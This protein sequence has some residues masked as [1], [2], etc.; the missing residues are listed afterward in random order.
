MKKTID[1]LRHF[2]WRDALAS[3]VPVVLVLALGLWAAVHF[4][5][6]APDEDLL[7][8]T[9]SE[10]PAFQAFAQQYASQLAEDGVRL[11]IEA[12]GASLDSLK[13]L[14]DPED[15]LRVAFVP[16]GLSETEES[17][18]RDSEVELVSLG[19]VSYEPI[20]VFHRDAGQPTRL[21]QLRGKRIAI[22]ERRST[23]ALLALRLLQASGVDDQ[24]SELL[25]LA[26]ED[27]RRQLQAGA[28]DAA[29]FI[30]P[31]E[32]A[33]LRALMNEPGLHAMNLAQAEAYTRQF[34]YLHRL[35]L[36]QGALDLER[37]IPAQDLNLLATTTVVVVTRN[38]HPALVSL[39]MKAMR[40]THAKPGLLHEPRFFPSPRDTDFPL[41]KD[42]E[43]FYRSGPPFLQR[44]L[45][46]WLATLIERAA[47]ALIPLLAILLPVLRFAPTLYGWRIRRRI[48]HWY[49]E[50]KYLEIQAQSA[51]PECSRDALRA[52]LD[53]IEDKV[54]H[55]TLPLA[56]TEHAY[57]LKEHIDLVR[58][59]LAGSAGAPAPLGAA[60]E[61]PT[62]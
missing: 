2:S 40:Q 26:S 61:A 11:E 16:D 38:L 4:I 51:S 56:F 62:R 41:S 46:F 50:L 10:N 52:Q 5:D 35:V 42:A 32:S 28:V 54:T 24:N 18:A 17:N 57:F 27:A 31:P 44:Y 21:T 19:G 33:L 15:P 12:G 23:T 8:A 9:G 30:G 3:S 48:Y 47:L 55:A 60:T 39:L 36:P 1:W 49:G 20:W 37:N 53:E 13:R 29:F 6:P 14:R 22:G 58:S 59:R 34:P 43:R 25:Y 45:P 7:I